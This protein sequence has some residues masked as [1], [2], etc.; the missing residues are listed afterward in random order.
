MKKAVL[1]TC[2][3]LLIAV[4]PAFG[5]TTIPQVFTFGSSA[6]YWTNPLVVNQF[7]N[8]LGTLTSVR[9]SIDGDMSALLTIVNNSKKSKSSTGNANAEVEIELTGPS[10]LT[11]TL[12]L[13]NNDGIDYM[14]GAGNSLVSSTPLTGSG[15][16]IATWDTVAILAAFTGSGTV[17]LTLD[18]SG[19]TNLY[20]TGGS[21]YISEDSTIAAGSNVSIAYTYHVPEPATIGLLGIGALAFLRR[22]K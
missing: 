19:A 2:V 5:L 22:K 10:G 15:N 4:V 17:N 9:I 18:A 8:S 13:T 12:N 11:Q 1:L 6:T 14:L 16:A 7:D 3:S 21:T 20:N